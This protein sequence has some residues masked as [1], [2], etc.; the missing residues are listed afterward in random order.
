MLHSSLLKNRPAGAA[1]FGLRTHWSLIS[2]HS[3]C[4]VQVRYDPN[5]GYYM[6]TAGFDG[7]SKLWSCRDHALLQ[8]MAGHEGKVMGADV[9]PDGTGTIATVS[10]DRTVKFWAPDT[11]EEP[12]ENDL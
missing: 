6:L 1:H 5:D 9:C 7:V 12:V 3:S 10:Y 11:Y 8:T 4:C 2:C